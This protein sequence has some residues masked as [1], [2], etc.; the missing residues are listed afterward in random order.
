MFHITPEEMLQAASGRAPVFRVARRPYMT[1]TNNVGQPA[2][3][4]RSEGLLVRRE[5]CFHDAAAFYLQAVLD[6]VP[7][8]VLSC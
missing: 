3:P 7:V 2:R 8:S 5:K 6:E 1:H 4:Q